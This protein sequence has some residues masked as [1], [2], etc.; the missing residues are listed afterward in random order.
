LK[1]R[2]AVSA[3][4]ASSVHAT[5]LNDIGS[6]PRGRFDPRIESRSAKWYG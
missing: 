2:T 5:A 4:A 6:S 1:S 3:I